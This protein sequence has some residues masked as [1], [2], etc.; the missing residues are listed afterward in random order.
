MFLCEVVLCEPC[1]GMWLCKLLQVKNEVAM[2]SLG[3]CGTLYR[4]GPLLVCGRCC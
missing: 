3:F 2:Q 4:V 1:I